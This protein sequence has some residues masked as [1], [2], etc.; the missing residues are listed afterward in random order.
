LP[1]NPEPASNVSGPRAAR[2]TARTRSRRD[3]P[4]PPALVGL[5]YRW[6]TTAAPQMR[7]ISPTCPRRP[8]VSP[9]T[10]AP[11]HQITGSTRPSRPRLPGS[12]TAGT[13]LQHPGRGNQSDM[14]TETGRVAAK[15]CATRTPVPWRWRSGGCADWAVARFRV[16]RFGPLLPARRSPPHVESG[17]SAPDGGCRRGRAGRR[18]R[19]S[20]RRSARRRQ[21]VPSPL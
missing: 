10:R 19:G 9:P 7:A 14:P 4:V 15:Q 13:R 12:S 17:A 6:C 3:T 2:W 16:P 1:R 20:G 21:C 18:R 8:G 5:I 11:G